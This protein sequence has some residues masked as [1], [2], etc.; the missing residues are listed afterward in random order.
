MVSIRFRLKKYHAGSSE[1]LGFVHF[2]G[3]TVAQDIGAVSDHLWEYICC[4]PPLAKLQIKVVIASV[5]S[6]DHGIG[7]GCRKTSHQIPLQDIID[8]TCHLLSTAIF[9]F[10]LHQF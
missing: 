2:I 7:C 6:P 5:V 4:L 9:F 8:M 1:A 10:N 3:D